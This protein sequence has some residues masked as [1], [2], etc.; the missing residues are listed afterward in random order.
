MRFVITSGGTAGHIY[1]A[2]A[3]AQELIATGHEVLFAGTPQGQEAHLIP[4]EG[5]PYKAFDATGFN[6]S[7][8][9]SMPSFFWRTATSTNLAKEWLKE[10]QPAAVA[11]F[12]GFASVPVCRAALQS[13]IPV[14][15]HEQNSR[16]GWA[17]RF[18]AR[19]KV[20]AV[21]LTYEDARAQLTFSNKTL[22]ELTGNPVRYS[23]I[24]L[25]E[26]AA[27]ATARAAFRSVYGIPADALVLMVFGG[28]QGARSINDAVLAQAATLLA[29]D[30]LHVLHITGP[31]QYTV[32]NA[33]LTQTL[34]P[35]LAQRWHLI[36][37]CTQMGE[38]YVAADLILSRAGA[39]SLAEIAVLGVPA[40]LVPFPYATDDHQTANARS[41]VQAGAARYI[42][43]ADLSKPVFIQ[44]LD[45]LLGDADIRASM[46]VAAQAGE[47]SLATERVTKLLKQIANK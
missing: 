34:D 40:L 33:Q 4:A 47:A 5:I 17:N 18:L 29:R 32:V 46:A 11:G 43:D 16:A 45:L 1:P 13:R 22:V 20:A 12:G 19:S 3:V 23:L 44:L 9:S 8:I 38:A 30:N 31:K 41:L 15:I 7:K 26:P 24:K 42:S 21:A 14:L 35:V 37:Y 25:A 2:L 6:R 28:S 10:I 39:S 27:R 36:D